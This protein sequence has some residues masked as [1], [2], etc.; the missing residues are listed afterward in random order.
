[1]CEECGISPC[2]LIITMIWYGGIFVASLLN[3]AYSIQGNKYSEAFV[4]IK[5]TD[6][7]SKFKTKFLYDLEFGK[8]L[9]IKSNYNSSLRIE[10]ICYL[11]TC[12]SESHSIK[13]KNCSKACFEQTKD[14]YNGENKCEQ[15]KCRV[16]YW[17][18]EES[19]CRV[20]NR[21]EKWRNTEIFKGSEIIKF[22]PYTQIKDKNENCDNGYR[23][24]GILN[25]EGDFLCLKE[26]Y[27]DFECPINK[28]VILSNNDTPSDNYN[29]KKYEIGDKNIF[30]TNE[31]TD[32]YLINDLFINF[33]KDKYDSNLQLIDEDSYLNFSKY[34]SIYLD[35]IP[36]RVKLN[37]VQ[38]RSD[39]TAKRMKD[40]QEIYDEKI[41]MY[42]PEKIQEMNI[43]AKNNKDLLVSLGIGAFA[44]FA[45]TGFFF[46][47]AYCSIYE[48]GKTDC[49]CIYGRYITPM[50]R[51]ITFIIVFFPCTLL[52]LISLIYAFSKKNIYEKYLSMKYINEYKYY[53]YDYHRG[54]TDTF[55][56]SVISINF[57]I[58][59][60]IINLFITIMY[61]ILIRIIS[62]K[63]NS[64]IIESTSKKN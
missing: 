52:S 1:M 10:E 60:L 21:L 16:D 7:K 18:E 13:I 61:P 50:K 27:S 55:E 58:T 32:G 14:C 29:Y 47:T 38:Y 62:R 56:Q 57:Q 30:F 28:I 59:C 2:F 19:E 26:D 41:Q 48:C 24:C 22:I 23:R 35:T 49:N 20:F 31:N 25:K 64:Y 42:S 54:Y 51:V 39:I 40:Y 3:M 12:I 11:G 53:E 34:N 9:P 44:S 45:L 36:S 37:I 5:L 43:N 17:K 46:L 63:N 4:E 8:E 15:N 6:Y 33:D